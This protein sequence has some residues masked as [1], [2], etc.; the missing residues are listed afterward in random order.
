M[1]KNKTLLWAHN[2]GPNAKTYAGYI[3]LHYLQQ[4]K[5]TILYQVIG[6]QDLYPTSTRTEIQNAYIVRKAKQV[7]ANILLHKAKCTVLS[8]KMN[9]ELCD[10]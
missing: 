2:W 6:M 10:S 5:L 7:M 3:Q 1:W 4:G 9:L 8:K